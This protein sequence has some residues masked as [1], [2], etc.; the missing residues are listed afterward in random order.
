MVI[1]CVALALVAGTA[2]SSRAAATITPGVIAVG[3]DLT[4]PPYNYFDDNEKPA[5]FDV[6]LMTAIAAKAGMKIEFHDTRFENLIMGVRGGQFDV[7]AST[8]YVKPARAKQIDYIPYM[9]TGVSI[10]VATSSGLSFA[11]PENLCG[12]K[13]GSI[14][15]GAWIEKLNGLAEGV[16]KDNPVDSR[17]FPT[18]PEVTQALLSG[19]IDAQ[20]EDS[21]VLQS[22][23][24]KLNGRLKV[25]SK[26]NLYPVV[27][28]FGVRK[29]NTELADLLRKTL[30]E[31][32]ADG[33]YPALLKK[34]NVSKPTEAE[35]KAAVGE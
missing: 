21:A 4:Y 27:V 35:F 2:V 32:E 19:G 15:G 25:T 22:A 1:Y 29:G 17:E 28:G 9:K 23:V 10:A 3:T 8:L 33:T 18:S 16:C 30:K 7:I 6:E 34:Y 26:E 13:V 24:E 12:R 14:K 31:L 5:G 11:A 20:M